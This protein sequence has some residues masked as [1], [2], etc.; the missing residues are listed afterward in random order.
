MLKFKERVSVCSGNGNLFYEIYQ[1]LHKFYHHL[2]KVLKTQK[3]NIL[4]IICKP[5]KY[6][7]F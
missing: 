4:L 6:L 7:I 1:H 2:G 3:I 5:L